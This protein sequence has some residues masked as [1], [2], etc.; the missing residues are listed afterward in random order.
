MKV[1]L[2]LSDG[3]RPDAITNIP[4]AKEMMANGSYAPDAK[5]VFP[6]VTLPCHV[7]LFHSVDPMRHGTTTNTYM[8]QVRPIP[9][10]CEV[11]RAAGK[12][13]AFFYNWEELRDLAR[14]D[15]LMHSYFY[16]GHQDGW[17][18]KANEKVTKAAIDYIKDESPDFVFL[19][20]GWT[21]EAGHKYGWMTEEYNRA[22][23]ESWKCIRRVMDVVDDEYTVIVTA[24]H[25]GHERTHGTELAEDMTI[26]VFLQGTP[27]EKGKVLSDVSILDIAPTITKLLGAE[28]HAE[29]EGTSLV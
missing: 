25:G 5:T 4:Q 20:L 6:S 1:I 17:Y 18:E 27:F 3:M 16:S 21:D 24:D 7:S 2:I 28:P 23:Q 9:G 11:L 15:S 19:Y 13:N 26:P 14:P 10:L 29:W 22:I 8:P 12:K